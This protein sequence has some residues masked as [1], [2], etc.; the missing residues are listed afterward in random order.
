[1]DAVVILSVP[2]NRPEKRVASELQP[3]AA[4]ANK[5]AAANFT[6]DVPNLDELLKRIDSTYS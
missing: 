3:V 4:L 5:A 2:S 6:T 1:M